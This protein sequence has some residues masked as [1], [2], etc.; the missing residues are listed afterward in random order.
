MN[1]HH[2]F[3]AHCLAV[4]GSYLDIAAAWMKLDPLRAE[5]A[6]RNAMLWNEKARDHL[7]KAERRP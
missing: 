3:A 6:C 2:D 7:A 5:T 1:R 4:A